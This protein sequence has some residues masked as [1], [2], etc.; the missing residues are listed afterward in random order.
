MC[1][2]VVG[3]QCRPEPSNP[4]TDRPQDTALPTETGR[5]DTG[6]EPPCDVPEVE[7]N[8]SAEQATPLPLEAKACGEFQ[9]PA[10]SDQW[11]VSVTEE[12]WLGIAID[13]RESGSFANPAVVLSSPDGLA[14]LRSDGAETADVDLLFPTTPRELNV[15]VLE[16]NQQGSPDGQY[17]YSILASVQKAPRT[18]TV[19]EFEPNDTRDQATVVFDG[20]EVFAR[21]SDADDG[22]YYRVDVPVGRHTLVVA[23]HGFELGSPADTVLY[24]QDDT[25]TAPDCIGN[26]S[27]RFPRGQI[28][29]ERDPWLEYTS[30]G[31]ETLYIRV[32]PEDGRG[33]DVHWYGFELSLTGQDP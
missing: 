14:V 1:L 25:G 15:L 12:V 19:V 30:E 23:V 5:L 18:W 13:A 21:I 4:D 3:C 10:D 33:S 16:E 11:A 26:P 32:L 27:C 29:F 9:A 17:F 6:P 31:D 24:L 7:P 2:F 28:G 20:D 22:D 8:N